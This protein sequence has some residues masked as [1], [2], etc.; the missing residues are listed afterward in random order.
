MEYA[1]K[2]EP[3]SNHPG[4]SPVNND[5]TG[6]AACCA[7]DLQDNVVVIIIVWCAEPGHLSDRLL[8]ELYFCRPAALLTIRSGLHVPLV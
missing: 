4:G 3:S 7:L 1:P 6:Y 2:L 5:L 8:V